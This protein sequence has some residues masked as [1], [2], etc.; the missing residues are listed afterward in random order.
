[1]GQV[2]AWRLPIAAAAAQRQGPRPM[3]DDDALMA[4]AG[5][6]DSDAFAELVRR[7]LPRIHAM[8]Q[9][10]L[11]SVAEAEEVAQEALLRLWRQAPRWREGAARPGT[12]LYRVALNLCID[13]RRRPA[14]DALDAVPDPVD[15]APS[16][17]GRLHRAETERA[18]ATAV[19]ELPERQRAALVLCFYEGLGN[20]EAASVMEIS[21]GALESLLVRAKRT[22]K[23]KL[24]P[25]AGVGMEDE[26]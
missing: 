1:M 7:H 23:E 20:I 15:P 10:M 2:L 6:G 19:A 22:L 18:V 9:R 17:F 14:M 12:W 5:A 3:D 26:S 11:G 21:V 8:A 25:L 24:A 4:R 16:P 13:R